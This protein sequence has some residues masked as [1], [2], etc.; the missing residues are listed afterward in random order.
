M[1]E[2]EAEKTAT[3]KGPCD[4]GCGDCGDKVK[5]ATVEA[6]PNNDRRKL[7]FGGVIATPAIVMLSS[8]SALAT[9]GGG[10]GQCTASAHASVNL[11]KPKASGCKSLSPGCWKN[12]RNW[13]SP[14]KPGLPDPTKQNPGD[15]WNSQFTVTDAALKN[16][17]KNVAQC[18]TNNSKL[19]D[20][21]AAFRAY[22][23]QASMTGSYFIFG[24]N[25]SFMQA[26][27]GTGGGDTSLLRA[28]VACVLNAAQFGKTAFG[29]SVAEIV[30]MINDRYD[31]D[32]IRLAADLE[33]LTSDRGGSCP[34]DRPINWCTQL[35][36]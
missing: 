18:T 3:A 35:N 1:S 16:Y 14:F 17:F 19:N 26:L 12:T 28:A 23:T 13:P 30:T 21:V 6:Q 33:Y 9:G 31:N 22:N 11:S 32:K 8:R 20:M 10:G 2:F 29:Y 4:C 5:P 7:L 24:G 27:W 15:A 36:T 34:Q 25:K